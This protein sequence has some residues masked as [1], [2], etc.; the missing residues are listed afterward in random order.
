LTVSKTESA[1]KSK[2]PGIYSAPIAFFV[3]PNH[4]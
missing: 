4:E 3:I 2:P 1:R